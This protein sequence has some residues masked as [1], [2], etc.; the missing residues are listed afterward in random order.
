[1]LDQFGLARLAECEAVNRQGSD[2][3]I[4][5]GPIS[6]ERVEGNDRL[7]LETLGLARFDVPEGN[8]LAVRLAVS[9]HELGDPKQVVPEVFA[10]DFVWRQQGTVLVGNLLSDH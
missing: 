1:M 10:V 5:L 4:E 2:Y 8:K 3:G 9:F 6:A 7:G